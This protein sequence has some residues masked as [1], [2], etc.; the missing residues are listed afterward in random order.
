MIE[1][2]LPGEDRRQACAVPELF[3]QGVSCRFAAVE[4]DTVAT[5]EVHVV[6]VTGHPTGAWVAQQARNLLMN[7]DQ[8]A[9]G[10]RFLLRDRDTK[11]TEVFDAVFAAEGIEV[12]RTPPPVPRANSFAERWVGTVRRGQHP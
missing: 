8:R 3:A 9:A 12:I 1:P 7:L 11:F 5:R 10:L 6:G 2:A 4:Q